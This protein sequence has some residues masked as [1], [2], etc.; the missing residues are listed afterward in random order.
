MS[1]SGDGKVLSITNLGLRVLLP[2][3]YIKKNNYIPSSF[4]SLLQRFLTLTLWLLKHC[5]SEIQIKTVD[6]RCL[7]WNASILT[8]FSIALTEERG[9]HFH[10]KVN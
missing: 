2:D 10:Q 8:V 1:C 7:N 5:C 6:A 4:A 3:A 9:L